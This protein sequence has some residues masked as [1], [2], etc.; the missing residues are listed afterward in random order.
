MSVRWLTA[1]ALVGLTFAL[2]WAVSANVYDL[3]SATSMEIAAVSATAIG[4][5]LS[6]W[7]FRGQLLD[8]P[9][10]VAWVT[11][12]RVP[13][14]PAITLR[15]PAEES[16]LDAVFAAHQAR[17]SAVVVL[18][19]PS[20][21]GKSQLAAGYARARMA[22]GWPLVAWVDA[23]QHEEL[24]AG[25]LEFADA[26]SLRV[27]E[28][29]GGRAVER[30]RQHP[31]TGTQPSVIVFDG[32]TDVDAVRPYLPT[33]SGWRV[34][35][36][37]SAPDAHTLGTEIAL[38]PAAGARLAEDS[39]LTERTCR[40]LGK[41]PAVLDL[42]AATLREQGLDESSYLARLRAVP[43][44]QLLGDGRDGSRHDYPPRAA[45]AALLALRGAGF[46]TDPVTRRLV[47]LLA[48]LA[49]GGA[50]REV[51][52]H[53]A[54]PHEVD[55]AVQLLSRSALVSTRM[56]Q[57]GVQLHELSRRVV[58]DRL[59]AEDALPLVIADAADLLWSCTFGE[60]QAWE[61]RGEGDRL[62][63]HIAAL[64]TSAG[65]VAASLSP[66]A[67]ERVLGLGQWATRQLSAVGDG[68]RAVDLADGIRTECR[69]LLGPDDPD[70]LAASDNL[71][72]AY[73]AAGRSADAVPLAEDVLEARERV[74]GPEHPDTLASRYSLGYAH[75]YAGRLED[76]AAHYDCAY[77]AYRRA[78][79]PDNAQTAT[80]AGALTRVRAAAP[81]SRGRHRPTP[82]AAPQQR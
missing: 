48:V 65:S 30:L 8:E 9:A 64:S 23:G 41:L 44:G 26:I 29:G 15:R 63:A 3:G 80:V 2:A 22:E 12:R 33:M 18:T 35:V 4:V 17:T 24:L 43:T 7:S 19:G 16:S 52:H 42:A 47:G 37:S 77:D 78:Y 55:E 62:V 49:P 1:T 76:A 13:A 53:A 34:I 6:W 39:G 68:V 25:L 46:E 28:E 36:T 79:G 40:D 45:G 73:V 74:L 54:S 66:A 75:E 20:G 58:T 51:L 69:T 70:S 61:R 11:W 10:E 59:R 67:T 82:R 60:E 81:S 27:P 14:A 32:V 5:P 50:G 38:G 72:I 31:P 56:D 21:I 71:V 57:D